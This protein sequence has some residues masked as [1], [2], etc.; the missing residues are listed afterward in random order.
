[1]DFNEEMIRDFLLK[2]ISQC[3]KRISSIIKEFTVSKND[4]YNLYFNEILDFFAGK[5]NRVL[6]LIRENINSRKEKFSPYHY[7]DIDTL[8]SYY[9]YLNTIIQ[10]LNADEN[11]SGFYY[12]VKKTQK[13]WYENRTIKSEEN[14]F[15]DYINPIKEARV[16]DNGY[17]KLNPKRHLRDES[18][19]KKYSLS[20]CSQ[21]L[22][23]YLSD[24]YELEEIDE[25]E[26][27][28]GTFEL[29]KDNQKYMM[30]II[31]IKG[32][33][34]DEDHYPVKEV[35]AYNKTLGLCE[36]Y[37]YEN[38][39][40]YNGSLYDTE[41]YDLVS[42]TDGLEIINFMKNEEKE[43]LSDTTEQIINLIEEQKSKSYRYA[44]GVIITEDESGQN[45]FHFE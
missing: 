36:M 45:T 10:D 28:L 4:T 27:E 37:I 26:V 32:V 44:E 39:T 2:R 30:K 11:A 5:D 25:E 14:G 35:K 3:N 29:C 24:K 16:L 19:F 18:F 41:T 43:N 8:Y 13:N 9:I 17:Y 21:E 12:T 40:I 34:L 22:N 23:A 6:R 31:N 20:E 42:T 33:Y 7:F 1:M 38:G 15:Y